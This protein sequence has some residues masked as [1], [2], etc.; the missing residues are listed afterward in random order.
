MNKS[1][2]SYKQIFKNTSLFGGVQVIQLIFTLLKAKLIAIFIGAVGMGISALFNTTV[3]LLVT[4]SN[5]G[6]NTSALKDISFVFESNNEYKI[7]QLIS[8]YKKLLILSC[9]FG[10]LL[11]ITFS[12]LLSYLTFGNYLYVNSF[13]ILTLLLI[14]TLL[15]QGYL[16]ILQGSKNIK[17][18]TLFSIFSIIISFFFSIPFYLILGIKGIIPGLIIPQWVTFFLS[19]FFLK[20]LNIKNVKVNKLKVFIIG[21]KMLKLGFALM[22]A[23]FIGQFTKLLFNLYISKFG[24]LE[25]LGY[26]NAAFGLTLTSVSLVF[27]SLA[28]DYLPRLSAICNNNYL[29]NETVNRQGIIVLLIIFPILIFISLFS[30][31]IINFFLSKDFLNVELLIKL[32]SYGM[33]YKVISFT[34]MYIPIAFG[35]KKAYLFIEA[36]WNNFL[37]LFFNILGYYIFGLNGLGYSLIISS[38]V[39]LV[40]ISIYIKFKYNFIFTSESL[41]IFFIV[42][43]F[44]SLMFINSI[45][46]SKIYFY[47]IGFIIL[48]ISLS[49]SLNELNKRINFFNFIKSAFKKK[50]N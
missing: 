32:L 34:L 45:Y 38:I 17:I 3:S 8:I 4:F 39:Y 1:P 37:I 41:K 44:S 29:M 6:L 46:S 28:N 13:I 15:T 40:T 23:I 30:S 14:P 12:S 7:S 11:M 49:F 5:L 16:T 22:I 43:L 24:T 36:F 27:T 2:T 33:V 21:S 47:I 25:D 26:I 19:L 31:F 10:T 42:I 50:F 35:D 18:V 20:K 48:I 9:A